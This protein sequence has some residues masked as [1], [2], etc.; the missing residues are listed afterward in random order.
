MTKPTTRL[1]TRLKLEASQVKQPLWAKLLAKLLSRPSVHQHLISWA[2]SKP[3]FDIT[4]KTGQLYMRRWWLVPG[5]ALAPHPKHGWLDVKP[6]WPF[7]WRIHQ[8]VMPDSD[9]H[10]HNHPSGY[11]T[12][13]LKGWYRELS[14]NPNYRFASAQVFGETQHGQITVYR[15]GDTGK[16]DANH[17]HLIEDLSNVGED[18]VW[19]LFCL[20]NK[21]KQEWGFLVDGK[22]VHWKDYLQ[23]PEGGDSSKH[24]ERTK[25]MQWADY[26]PDGVDWK[27]RKELKGERND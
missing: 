1:T 24:W 20:S 3:Y 27:S 22:T 5:F 6:W 14:P 18:G 12:F 23:T 21:D 26:E 13:I 8:I 11:R 2:Q 7:R 4:D 17:W 16:K 25:P 15:A 19:T 10:Y 9:R